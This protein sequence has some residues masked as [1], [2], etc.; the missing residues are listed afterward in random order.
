MFDYRPHQ[1]HCGLTV[2]L[3]SSES[4][5]DEG[6]TVKL[7]PDPFVAEMEKLVLKGIWAAKAEEKQKQAQADAEE[8]CEYERLLKVGVHRKQVQLWTPH[9]YNSALFRDWR[10]QRL[11]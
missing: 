3:H 6:E 5:P 1:G 11:R 10:N 9:H 8:N 7:S 2:P 4:S